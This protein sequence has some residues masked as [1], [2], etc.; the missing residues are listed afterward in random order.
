MILNRW[1]TAQ[2][3]GGLLLVILILINEDNI[4]DITQSTSKQS[5][6]PCL[7]RKWAM[8]LK[9]LRK[10]SLRVIF[11]SRLACSWLSFLTILNNGGKTS[12]GLLPQ[13]N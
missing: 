13:K 1:A 5:N 6:K 10:L 9:R 7:V 8:N 3:S 2:K 4:T 11:S 12:I